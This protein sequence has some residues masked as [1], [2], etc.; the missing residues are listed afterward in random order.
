MIINHFYNLRDN[1]SE[2]TE[3]SF[4]VKKLK[5]PEGYF[6]NRDKIDFENITRKVC[7][8]SILSYKAS[9]T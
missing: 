9:E 2:S 1:S 4:K 8:D 3:S 5:Y 6:S 7:A